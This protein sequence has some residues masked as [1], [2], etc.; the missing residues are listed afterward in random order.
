VF[1]ESTWFHRRHPDAAP[2]RSVRTAD[3]RTFAPDESAGARKDAAL[4]ARILIVEDD[5]LVACDAE[6]ALI[7]AGFEVVGVAGSADEALELARAQNPTLALVDVRLHG[8]RDGIHA[9]TDLLVN[10]GI[11][12]IFATAHYDQST[13]DRAKAAKPLGW[14]EKPYSM[15]ALVSAVRRAVRELGHGAPTG[16][17]D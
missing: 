3:W 15:F 1:T 14:L 17:G 16:S 6:G 7:G 8:E 2:D 12:S 4:A 10:F 5:F 11:R 9:A 13:L